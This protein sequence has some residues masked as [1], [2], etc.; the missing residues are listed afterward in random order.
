MN[1][2]DRLRRPVMRLL[3]NLLLAWSPVSK[4]EHYEIFV[5][6]ST[7]IPKCKLQ[8]Q[9]SKCLGLAN[10]KKSLPACKAFQIMRW[11]WSRDKPKLGKMV[12]LL[13][14]L[15]HKRWNESNCTVVR[16]LTRNDSPQDGTG[17]HPSW[18]RGRYRVALEIQQTKPKFHHL[19]VLCTQPAKLAQGRRSTNPHIHFDS[20]RKKNKLAMQN[21]TKQVRL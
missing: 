2:F 3:L 13:H 5:S 16:I 20:H 8:C 4:C 15:D 21:K 7:T 10:R 18:D 11:G 14:N 17:C 9:I 6:Y 19:L 12:F 1:I